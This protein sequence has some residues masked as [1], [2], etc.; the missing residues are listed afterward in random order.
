MTGSGPLRSYMASPYLYWLHSRGKLF[1]KGHLWPRWTPALR[2][3]CRPKAA[4]SLELVG[5]AQD[6]VILA[7]STFRR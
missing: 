2:E 4:G 3:P 6:K 1:A 7:A 5:V